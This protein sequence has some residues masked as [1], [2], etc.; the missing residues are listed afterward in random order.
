MSTPRR[1]AA[2]ISPV[3]PGRALELT[4][5]QTAP[6]ADSTASTQGTCA[7]QV[8]ASE[9]LEACSS[10]FWQ[11][12]DFIFFQCQLPPQPLDRGGLGSTLLPTALAGRLPPLLS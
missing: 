10:Y 9:G 5:S 11:A 8:E 12:A 1:W 7:A 6:F 4:R 2:S 3:N